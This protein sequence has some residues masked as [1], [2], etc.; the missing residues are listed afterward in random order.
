MRL[1][2]RSN[3]NYVEE[4]YDG[5]APPNTNNQVHLAEEDLL[6]MGQLFDYTQTSTKQSLESALDKGPDSF[7]RSVPPD[8]NEQQIFNEG[9]GSDHTNSN[10]STGMQATTSRLED[11]AVRSYADRPSPGGSA[12]NYFQIDHESDLSHLIHIAR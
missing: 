3:L 2:H 8:P 9:Q 5:A 4:E 1:P 11:I 7:L 10:L 6:L 12:F